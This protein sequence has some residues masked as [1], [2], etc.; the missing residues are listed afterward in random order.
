MPNGLMDRQGNL[1]LDF[2]VDIGY[3]IL[4]ILLTPVVWTINLINGILDSKFGI[5][6]YHDRKLVEEYLLS[7]IGTEKVALLKQALKRSNLNYEDM[8]YLAENLR[9]YNYL[10]IW[11]D[12]KDAD[13][14]SSEEKAVIEEAT[15]ELNT[16]PRDVTDQIIGFCFC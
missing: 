3:K 15:V 7:T 12:Y 13:A 11:M 5:N 2:M 10:D 1:F 4:I 16:A 6:L 8:F 14:F 9:V